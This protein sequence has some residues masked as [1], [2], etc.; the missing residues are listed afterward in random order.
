VFRGE[1]VHREKIGP[2]QE[3]KVGKLQ[4]F[5]PPLINRTCTSRHFLLRGINTLFSTSGI[6]KFIL[7]TIQYEYKWILNRSNRQSSQ[8]I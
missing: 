8:E 5:V 7:H 4:T 6:P 3:C 1:N 2:K